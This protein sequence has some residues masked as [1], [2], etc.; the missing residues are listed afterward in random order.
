MV[1]FYSFENLCLSPRKDHFIN[2]CS[3]SALAVTLHRVD[4][5]L[6]TDIPGLVSVSFQFKFPCD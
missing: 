4:R 1:L 5:N 2:F 3:Y 6:F